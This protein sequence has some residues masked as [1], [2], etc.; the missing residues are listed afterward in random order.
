MEKYDWNLL[1]IY[2]DKSEIEID[3]KKVEQ[4][5]LEIEKYKGKLSVSS[6]NMYE[7]YSKLETLEVLLLK[8]CAYAMLKH[9][10]NMAEPENLKLYK[11]TQLLESKISSRLS[12]ITPEVSD[13]DDDV[14]RKFLEENSK[15]KEYSRI[16]EKIIKYKKHILNKEGKYIVSRLSEVLNSMDNIYTMLSD[17]DFKFGSFKVDGK[18][19]DVTHGKYISLLSS[20]NVEV[21]KKAFE[22]MYEEYKKYI[23]TITELYLTSVKKNVIISNLENYSSSLESAV[24]SDDSTVSVYDNLIKSVNNNLNLNY[25]YMKL[26]KKLLKLDKMHMYDVYVNALDENKT[27]ITYDESKEI[28]KSALEV[29]GKDYIDVINRAFEEGWIDVYE[30]ENKNS[31]AYSMGVYGIHPYILANY[32][33]DIEAVSTI[34]HELGHTMHSYFASNEQ[35]Y[36]NSEY[37]ILVAEVA[38]TVNEILLSEYLINKETNKMK[39]ASLINNQLDRVRATL[40]RQTM[41]AEFEKIVHEK[42]E[43]EISLT[44]DDLCDIYYELNKKYFGEDVISDEYIRYEWA[45]IP[46]FYR[47]FYVYKYATGISSAISI[48]TKILSGKSGYVNRYIDML[49]QGGAKD[50]LD[51]LR[52]VDVDLETEEPVNDAFLYFEKKLN[53]LEE[54]LK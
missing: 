50:S 26:K 54:L 15:L 34:A 44:A 38:S 21:R 3:I 32:S 29:Y 41:F 8:V 25:R 2:S 5:C 7:C 11:D 35:N 6:E 10:Q 36:F 46:H 42:V 19:Y 9:H 31:G 52:S 40:I 49:K 20:E 27:K 16:I 33:D 30:K 4:L 24:E 1:D 51:L 37:T 45:R 53:E 43:Q 22:S 17:V 14:L 28:I 18:K 13:I 12:F 47:D 39:K 48:A 23:N